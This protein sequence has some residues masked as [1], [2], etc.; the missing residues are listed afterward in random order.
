MEMDQFQKQL[1]RLVDTY[2]AQAYGTERTTLIWRD[3][4]SFSNEWLTWTVDRFLGSCRIAP[5]PSEFSEAAS[6]ERE[7]VW[8]EEKAKNERQAKDF[9][10]Q[11][12]PAFTQT[13]F[14]TIHMRLSSELSDPDFKAFLST[15]DHSTLKTFLCPD[16]E[17][18]GAVLDA[19]N[20][21]WKCHCAAGR[22]RREAWPV[23]R[24]SHIPI[25]H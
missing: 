14:K 2:G 11:F 21:A 12:P 24:K 7:R 13:I 5:L 3:V 25:S 22:A 15:L 9:F 8:N 17:D 10:R 23:Y 16:C 1:K 4:Q 20:Y 19:N 18:S 6:Q